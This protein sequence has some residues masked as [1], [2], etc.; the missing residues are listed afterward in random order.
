LGLDVLLKTRDSARLQLLG[1][2]W[3]GTHRNKSQQYARQHENA[4]EPVC[5]SSVSFHGENMI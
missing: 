5:H 1:I 3:Q 4:R 2:R